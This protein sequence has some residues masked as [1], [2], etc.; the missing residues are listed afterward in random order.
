MAVSSKKKCPT[1]SGRAYPALQS[2]RISATILSRIA[3]APETRKQGDLVFDIIDEHG[4]VITSACLS[5]ISIDPPL[6]SA[7]RRLTFPDGTLF[8]TDDH[9][10]VY[11]IAGETRGSI[12]HRLEQ[13]RPRLAALVLTCIAAVWVLWRFGLDIMVSA[14]IA[15]TPP[16]VIEQIDRGTLKTIDFMMAEETLL[17]STEKARVQ[18]IFGRLLS[19]LDKDEI[20]SSNF[21][22]IF[23]SMPDVGPNAFA[24]P[25]GT[26]VMTD[27]FID[28]FEDEDVLAGVLGHEI[29][30]V[31]EKHGLRQTYRS[32]SIYI[33]VAFLAGETGPF[34][35]ELLLEGNLVLS[36]AYSRDH[37]SSADQFGLR[38]AQ[39]AG[40]DPSGLK[41]F[42]EWASGRGSEQSK[43]LSTHPSSVERVKDIDAFIEKL[44]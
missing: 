23:R 39:D 37:E 27:E 40:F 2:S 10:G 38:L 9:E 13:F 25:N 31:I 28:L 33:L 35:E 4:A 1:L 43:W 8:E 12:I 19:H 36:L 16:V 3:L 44:Q 7:P 22:L 34:I 6:G 11:A 24:L 29:G 30:H 5:K 14:A 41:Q 42:F 17:E 18:E 15:L 26:V 21:K 20:S 32:L